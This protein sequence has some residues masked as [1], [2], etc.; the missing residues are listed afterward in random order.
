MN[1]CKSH[2]HPLPLKAWQ[3]RGVVQEKKEKKS[4]RMETVSDV[5]LK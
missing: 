3:I 5:F 4:E 1:D 2:P